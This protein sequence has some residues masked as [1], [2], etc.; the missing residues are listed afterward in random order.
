MT[1]RIYQPL[2][3]IKVLSFELAF[4]LPAGT[5]TLADLGAEV[6]R[7]A[8]PDHNAFGNYIS[9]IDGV[10]Q[11]KPCI[12]IDLKTDRGQ[13]LAFD[14]AMEADV[15]C[16]NYRPGVLDKFGLSAA[17]LRQ[18]RPA[19]I[20]L[21]LSGYGTPGPWSS[22]PAYGPSTEA[23]GG[24]N[25]LLVNEGE[26]PIRIG[27]GVFADQLAGLAAYSIGLVLDAQDGVLQIANEFL[28]TNGQLTVGFLAHGIRTLL[29]GFEGGR[30]IVGAVVLVVGEIFSEHL[31]VL[32]GL[33][34]LL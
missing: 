24:L 19:L 31:Q 5:R 30:R 16:N 34:D 26:M 17:A 21:Q 23:A 13:Q 32:F 29:K 18:A 28:L 7:V 22:Y 3:G 33:V 25:R 1:A 10:F 14:L 27:T 15:V 11:S 8:R 20:Y 12:A 4:A 9:V 2:K 6:V